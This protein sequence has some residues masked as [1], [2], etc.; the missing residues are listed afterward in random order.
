MD[1]HETLEFAREIVRIRDQERELMITLAKLGAG[2][3]VGQPA[4]E[5]VR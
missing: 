2:L 4:G 1:R 3:R 5:E